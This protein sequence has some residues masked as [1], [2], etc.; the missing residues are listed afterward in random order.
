MEAKIN[1]SFG[2]IFIGNATSSFDRADI[3][4]TFMG[5]A[6]IASGIENRK[7]ISKPRRDKIGG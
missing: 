2:D 5:N 4:N 6:A 1:Q 7:V 3:E